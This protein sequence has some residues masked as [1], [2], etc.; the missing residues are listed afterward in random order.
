MSA[1][2]FDHLCDDMVGTDAQAIAQHLNRKM[3]IA[4]M[5]GD[6]HKFTAT[7][8]KNLE[9][10]LWFGADAYD[11]AIGQRKTVSVAEMHS[12]RQIHLHLGATHAVE[13]D[14]TAV[15]VVVVQQNAIDL[16]YGVPGASGQD[17]LDSHQNRK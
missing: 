6:P 15:P 7:V 8:R 10:F 17:T 13:H 16:A 3:P 12:L 11:G 5:P 4:E 14:P 2:H 1:Q 9:Q